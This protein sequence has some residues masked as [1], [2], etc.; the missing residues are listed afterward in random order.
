MSISGTSGT[1]RKATTTES[2]GGGLCETD[3]KRKAASLESVGGGL[4][5]TD[6][7]QLDSPRVTYPAPVLLLDADEDQFDIAVA[8]L[9]WEK[10]SEVLEDAC[11]R[12][13]VQKQN[14]PGIFN[15][16]VA[17]QLISAADGGKSPLHQSTPP[18][19]PKSAPTTAIVTS[20][21]SSKSSGTSSPPKAGALKGPGGTDKKRRNCKRRDPNQEPTQPW[22]EVEI[23]KFRHLVDTEGA[24]NWKDKSAK[25]EAMC[26]NKRT[27]KALHTRYLR[28]IGRIIDRPR[29]KEDRAPR[30]KKE[31]GK[32][33]A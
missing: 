27:P 12:R 32:T 17:A 18:A 31:D 3:I 6:V 20:G 29:K 15:L 7:N 19:L 28:E 22:S 9:N 13:P 10:L 16:C 8:G 4:C 14:A 30:Y 2:V 5:E 21:K 23:G 26:G 11:G 24:T 33:A 1:K 25:L